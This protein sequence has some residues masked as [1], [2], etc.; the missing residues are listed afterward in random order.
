MEYKRIQMYGN[1]MC[2]NDTP[3]SARRVIEKDPNIGRQGAK[4]SCAQQLSWKS[5]LHEAHFLNPHIEIKI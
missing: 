3:M 2:G 1:Q 4:A 5:E